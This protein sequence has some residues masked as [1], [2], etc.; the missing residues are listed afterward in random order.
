MILIIDILIVYVGVLTE[1]KGDK[2]P[3]GAFDNRKKFTNQTIGLKENDSIYI[4]SDGYAD[5]FGGAQAKKFKYNQF[6]TMLLAMQEKVMSD[7]KEIINKTIVNWM[8]ELEQIDDICVIG[9][10]I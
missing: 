7:Q 6:K 9:I 8:G 1:F 4:F 3:I 5:Q 10:K 2:Q